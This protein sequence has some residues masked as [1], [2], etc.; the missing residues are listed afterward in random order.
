MRVYLDLC[1][2]QR[3]FDDQSQPRVR[4]EA[5]AVLSVL[6]LSKAGSVVLVTSGAHV[7]EIA[8]C[9]F[10]DRRA[11]VEDVLAVSD[12]YAM[13]V[14]AVLRRAQSYQARGIKRFDAIHLASAVEAG[15]DVFCTTDDALLKRGREADTAQAAVVSPLEL[16]V[17]LS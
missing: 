14:P 13:G 4:A 12:V 6:D 11:H 10:P 8:K 9:P 5:E 17:R 15:A 7:V 1:A 3:P 16:I 2:I